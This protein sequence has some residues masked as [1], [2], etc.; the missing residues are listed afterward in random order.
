MSLPTD[1]RTLYDET[2]A[3]W[4]RHRPSSLSDYTAR[5]QVM[6]LCEPVAGKHVLHGESP[7]PP[8]THAAAASGFAFTYLPPAALLFAPFALLP[9]GAAAGL[10]TA[11]LAVCAPPLYSIVPAPEVNVRPDK[12]G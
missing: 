5:P 9:V 10:F 1:P 4:A 8:V 12:T 3:R 11:G 6:A 7:F 2:A